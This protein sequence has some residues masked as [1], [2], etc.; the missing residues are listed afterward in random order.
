[1]TAYRTIKIIQ[2]TFVKGLIFK[3]YTKHYNLSTK[4]K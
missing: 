3:I 1:M 2:I 4:D